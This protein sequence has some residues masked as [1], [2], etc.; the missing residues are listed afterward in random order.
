MPVERQEQQTRQ[1]APPATPA[2]QPTPSAPPTPATQGGQGAAPTGPFRYRD[3][4]NVPTFPESGDY[5]WTPHDKDGDGELPEPDDYTP[6]DEPKKEETIDDV[7][8]DTFPE[9]E[10]QDNWYEDL[11]D[12]ELEPPSSIPNI[13]PSLGVR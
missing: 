13:S 7:I 12:P 5:P 10:R 4:E 11:S 1:E 6:A 8:N 2:V 3:A 9:H